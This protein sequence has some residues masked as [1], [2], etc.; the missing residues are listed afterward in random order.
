MCYA[1]AAALA[2]GLWGWR[3]FLTG[4]VSSCFVDISEV[5]EVSLGAQLPLVRPLLAIDLLP[6]LLPMRTLAVQRPQFPVLPMHVLPPSLPMEALGAALALVPLPVLHRFP[7]FPVSSK[8]TQ[9]QV[10]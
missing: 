3:L 2:G 5:N 9:S 8:V 6:V 10:S 7:R 1:D 4:W